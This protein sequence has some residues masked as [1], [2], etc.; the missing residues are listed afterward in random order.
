MASLNNT[1]IDNKMYINVL[2]IIDH[3]YNVPFIVLI[4]VMDFNTVNNV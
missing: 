1:Y 4:Y 3:I 2:S